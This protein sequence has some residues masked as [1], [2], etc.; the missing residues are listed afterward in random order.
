MPWYHTPGGRLRFRGR[1][2]IEPIAGWLASS[3]G[4]ETV[5][6]AAARIGF[7]LIGR[8]RSAERRVR[9]EL[10]AALSSPA[11][12]ATLAAVCDR[13]LK[14]WTEL[15]YAPALPRATVALRRLVLVPQTLVQ[16]RTLTPI[17]VQVAASPAL[18][19]LPAAFTMFLARWILDDMNR[20]IRRATPS[21][22]RPVHAHDAWACVAIDDEF[23]W[24]DPVWAGS[25]WRGHTMLF[26]M[27]DR[28]MRRRDRQELHAA[29]ERVRAALPG[30]SR[31]QRDGVLRLAVDGMAS[32]TT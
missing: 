27:P 10:Q 30:L 8:R 32:L 2:T 18:A 28:G 9:R 4:S 20:A 31:Q 24:I 13:Y 26:E 6:A 11:V 14:G 29:I 1:A 19:S 22:E 16:G 12:H 23:T 21:P 5:R 15:A 3:D 7:S 17:A 25:E